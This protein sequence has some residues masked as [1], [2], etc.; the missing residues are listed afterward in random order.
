MQSPMIVAIWDLNV[1][2]PASQRV[3]SLLNDLISATDRST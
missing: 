1:S 3:L 2:D